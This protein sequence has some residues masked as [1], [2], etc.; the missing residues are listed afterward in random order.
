MLEFGP[1]A[2][3]KTYQV[4]IAKVV[5]I[6]LVHDSHA[7]RLDRNLTDIVTRTLISAGIMLKRVYT[8]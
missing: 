2:C 1:Q 7:R 4:A 5:E 8:R 6:A 3:F